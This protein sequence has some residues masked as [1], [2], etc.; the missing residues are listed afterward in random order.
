M[1]SEKPHIFVTFK[2]NMKKHFGISTPIGAIG[3]MFPDKTSEEYKATVQLFMPLMM[4]MWHE[5]VTN[6][7]E[8]LMKSSE[9]I[10]GHIV[11]IWRRA[12][13][14]DSVANFPHYHILLWL[15]DDIKCLESLIKSTKKHFYHAFKDIFRSNFRIINSLDEINEIYDLFVSLQ[16]HDCSSCRKKKRFNR[17]KLSQSTV[18]PIRKFLAE[19]HS[20]TIF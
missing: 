5:T 16:S 9:R 14:Q 6:L 7:I 17:K 12:E 19:R 4:Q 13:F 15:L 18:S 8:Y 3:A 10:L 20:S 1:K 2:W 11:K